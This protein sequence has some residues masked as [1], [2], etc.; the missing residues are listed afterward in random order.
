[1]IKS[2]FAGYRRSSPWPFSRF[3]NSSDNIFHEF[4][5]RIQFRILDHPTSSEARLW[6]SP[7][8]N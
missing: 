2:L 7:N 5:N 1:M 8:I 4:I 6:A 3:I